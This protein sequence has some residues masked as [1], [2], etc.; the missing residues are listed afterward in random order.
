MS[1]AGRKRLLIVGCGYV[2]A[3]VVKLANEHFSVCALSR[4]PDRVPEFSQLGISHLLGDW[5]EP[6]TWSSLPPFDAILFSVPHRADEKLG[7]QTHVAGLKATLSSQGVASGTSPR[8]VYLST[9][10]VYGECQD[11]TVHEET[12]VN[13][14]RIG[15]EIALEAERWLASS[16]A[17]EAKWN[18]TVLRLA[19]IYGPGRIPLAAKLRA[20]EALAVPQQGYL[21]LVH[22]HDISRII[23]QLLLTDAPK[24]DTYVFSDSHPVQRLD[25]YQSL[26]ELCGVNEPQFVEANPQDSRARRATSK[27]VDASRI[28]GE[29]NFQYR[30]P[31]Y[32]S[33][34]IDALR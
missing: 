33:G 7:N 26:A 30:F 32:R 11:E 10:G 22:V 4:N 21:N 13:P 12:P 31:D 1:D 20:G 15:P 19:G 24:H 6:A 17:K 2:G 3:E 9:T 18:S 29:F 5:L 27:K 25:F 8:V 28:A 16:E 34:L 14:T 23:L